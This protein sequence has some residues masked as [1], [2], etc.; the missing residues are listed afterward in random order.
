MIKVT[1]CL[2]AMALAST[3]ACSNMSNQEQETLTG[4]GIG[5][6]PGAA[7]VSLFGGSGWS[8]AAIGAVAGGI[9]GNIRGKEVDN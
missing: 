7:I 8:G 6:A 3:A 5:A 9:T 1:Y 2:V 4:A